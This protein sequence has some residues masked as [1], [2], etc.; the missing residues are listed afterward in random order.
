MQ[1]RGWGSPA[2]H[3]LDV[4][5]LGEDELEDLV[6]EDGNPIDANGDPIGDDGEPLVFSQSLGRYLRGDEGRR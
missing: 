1:P 2:D 6:D 4:V 5:D 3:L